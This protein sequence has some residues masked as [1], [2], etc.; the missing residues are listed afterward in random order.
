MDKDISEMLAFFKSDEC[1]LWELENLFTDQVDF[2]TLKKMCPE[3][4]AT[5][6]KT[7]VE[8]CVKAL[9]WHDSDESEAH[10]DVRKARSDLEAKFRN[11]RHE[12]G[13]TFS[14]KPEY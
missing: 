3:P 10:A 2:E 5:I 12:T 6:I 8:K 1:N 14:A 4:L 13:K 7:I 11:H 9:E